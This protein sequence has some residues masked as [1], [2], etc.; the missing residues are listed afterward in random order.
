[1]N[2]GRLC[3]SWGAVTGVSF[4]RGPVF[5]PLGGRSQTGKISHLRYYIEKCY[6]SRG[7][8]I[9]VIGTVDSESVSHNL[10]SVNGT[11]H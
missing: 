8:L 10:N 2:H 5:F 11:G 4:P 1:M 7:V 9:V 3:W 6:R